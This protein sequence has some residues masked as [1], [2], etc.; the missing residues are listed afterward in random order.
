MDRHTYSDGEHKTTVTGAVG[1][2]NAAILVITKSYV[3]DLF[4]ADSKVSVEVQTLKLFRTPCVLLWFDNVTTVEKMDCKEL[5]AGLVVA[6]EFDNVPSEGFD[7]WMRTEFDVWLRAG[8]L[9]PK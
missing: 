5:M 2:S 8:G 3:K 4:I 1:S 9:I 7:E 6:K